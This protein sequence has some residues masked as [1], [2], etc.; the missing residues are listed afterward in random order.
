MYGYIIRERKVMYWSSQANIT[1]WSFIDGFYTYHCRM[2]SYLLAETFKYLYLL[3]TDA[4]KVGINLD[5][6]IFTT[7]AH[8]LP[9][10]LSM[11]EPKNLNITKVGYFI[12]N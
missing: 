12:Q 6:Y 5:N 2:D 9:L 3:F 4:D 7:E 8:L 10:S 1:I 11:K